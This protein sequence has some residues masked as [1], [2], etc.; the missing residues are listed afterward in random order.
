MTKTLHAPEFLI[1]EGTFVLHFANV[2]PSFKDVFNTQL[3]HMSIFV[4]QSDYEE[5]LKRRIIRNGTERG[6]SEE[7]VRRLDEQYL[8]PAFLNVM[9]PSAQTADKQINND[10]RQDL[11]DSIDAIMEV[12]SD[13]LGVHQGYGI[14]A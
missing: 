6:Q 12:L 2:M 5:T 4:R 9:L 1:V 3:S 13:K 14:T 8:R 7:V 11:E 10:I